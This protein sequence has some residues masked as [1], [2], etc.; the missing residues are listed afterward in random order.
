MTFNVVIERIGTALNRRAK[1]TGKRMGRIEKKQDRIVS[2][3]IQKQLV[4]RR[5]SILLRCL[6]NFVAVK[7]SSTLPQSSHSHYV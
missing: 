3:K 7:I 5:G 6:G 1:S 2:F 4:A